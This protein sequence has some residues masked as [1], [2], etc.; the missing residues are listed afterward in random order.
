MKLDLLTNATV[1]MLSGFVRS[2]NEKPKI[3]SS[4]SNEQEYK[5]LI[6]MKITDKI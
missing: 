1:V 4:K 6:M 5:D 3:S 2:P